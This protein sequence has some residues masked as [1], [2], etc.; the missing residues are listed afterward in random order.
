LDTASER[1]F[2]ATKSFRAARCA[3]AE[4]IYE[5]K[6]RYVERHRRR[7]LREEKKEVREAQE[8]YERAIADAEQARQDLVDCRTTWFWARFFPD[9]LASQ[10]PDMGAIATNLRKPVEAEL[11]VKTRLDACGVFR[12]LRRDAAILGE[13]MT[14][15][16]TRELGLVKPSESDVA[17]WETGKRDLIG[18]RF[19]AAWVGSED[20][21]V[22]NERIR[23]HHEQLRKRLRGDD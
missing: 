12:V 4:R 20:E 5:D 7:L 1:A 8:R 15:E 11:Q 18:P 2:R 23:N 3:A 22:P 9:E 21:K 13:A 10:A 16:Q 19:E 6:Q 17:K 14:H